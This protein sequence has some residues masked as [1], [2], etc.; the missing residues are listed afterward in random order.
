LGGEIL[1]WLKKLGK[2]RARQNDVQE[3]QGQTSVNFVNKAFLS[4]IGL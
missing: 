1:F 2:D 4:D 3:N